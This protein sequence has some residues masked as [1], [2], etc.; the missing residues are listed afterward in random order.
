M[1]LPTSPE[2]G[3]VD[4]DNWVSA[5]VRQVNQ[6]TWLA[7]T[8][9]NSWVNYGSTFQDGGYYKDLFNRVHLRGL[10][11]DGTVA[12]T[13]FTLPEGYRP[14]ATGIFIVISNSAIGRVDITSAGAVDGT[15]VDNN[16]VSLEGISFTAT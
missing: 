15:T 7:P 16:W 10:V 12:N 4:F 11:K 3:H 1:L 9:E 6:R 5:F 14:P 2:I 8:Y 13:I